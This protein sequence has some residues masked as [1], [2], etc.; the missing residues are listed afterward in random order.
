MPL[1]DNRWVT[2]NEESSGRLRAFLELGADTAGTAAGGAVGFLLGG[3]FG[4]AAGGAGGEIAAR[5]LRAV[6]S[7][8]RQRLLGPQEERRIATALTYA[9]DKTR[10][11][12]EQGFRV[13]DDGFFD[14][15]SDDRPAAEEIG[16]GVLIAAQREHEERKLRYYGNLLANIAFDSD[17]GRA[18]AAVLVRLVQRLSYR[19]IVLLALLARA[20]SS[21]PDRRVRLEIAHWPSEDLQVEIDDLQQ[22]RLVDQITA[23]ALRIRM[24]S[25]LETGALLHDLMELGEMEADE[26]DPLADELGLPE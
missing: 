18:K 19:Q 8:V 9:A 11:N 10:E 25:L 2:E 26:T 6:A 5:S 13:R 7:E 23:D 20:S 14:P 15:E 24:L 16:E 1:L 17:I 4:A 22:S 12:L 21:S 3:P